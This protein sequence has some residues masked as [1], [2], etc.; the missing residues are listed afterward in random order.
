MNFIF[1]I[2]KNGDRLRLYANG[3]QPKNGDCIHQWS[4]VRADEIVLD[5]A[6]T[7]IFPK[8]TKQALPPSSLTKKM[9]SVVNN[10]KQLIEGSQAVYAPQVVVGTPMC[11]G[12][13]SD[14]TSDVTVVMDAKRRY[15]TRYAVKSVAS[16]YSVL[17]ICGIATML[18]IVACNSF[19]SVLSLNTAFSVASVNSVASVASVNSVLSIFSVNCIGCAFNVPL[20]RLSERGNVCEKY[21]LTDD[22]DVKELLYGRVYD[23]FKPGNKDASEEELANDCC[24]Y[25]HSSEAEKQGL[26]GFILNSNRTA[27]MVFGGENGNAILG[28]ADL[29]S[30]EN[31]YKPVQQE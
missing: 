25:I 12:T 15:C 13:T 23:T 5:F 22:Q 20:T 4:Q 14:V 11:E 6:F 21:G 29:D 26:Q 19:C 28:R 17:S 2:K 24:L 16:M 3:A 10:K 30:A 31:I 9:C 8:Q 7:F 18:S 1:K 27:C